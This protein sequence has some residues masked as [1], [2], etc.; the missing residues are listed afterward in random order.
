MKISLTAA[1]EKLNSGKLVAVPTETVYG[2]AASLA[3]PKAIAEIFALKGRPSSNPLIVHFADVDDI[4][5]Y[6]ADFPKAFNALAAALWPGPLTLVL[7]AIEERVPDIVRAGL[8]TVACRLPD[9]PLTRE[10]LKLTGPLVMPSANLSGLPSATRPAHVETDFGSDFPVLDGGYCQCGVESTIL[11]FIDKKWQILRL[12][13]IPPQAVAEVLGYLP[14]QHVNLE[15]NRPLC[16]GQLF[17]H[18][19]PAATL[20]ATTSPLPNDTVGVMIGFSDRRYPPYM[21]VITL[22]PSD[23]PWAAAEQLYAIF[24]MIDALAIPAAW[25]DLDFP[26][27]GLW[28]TIRER[29]LRAIEK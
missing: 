25:I 5:P 7:P 14:R 9:H 4:T 8:P 29:I 2:L 6:A 23:D 28:D 10:L 19:A 24:R 20:R 1:A 15:A 3:H 17:R 21:E 18:Y 22:G 27:E 16:P 12:G 11:A 13:A 26:H